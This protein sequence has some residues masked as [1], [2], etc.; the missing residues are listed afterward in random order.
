MPRAAPLI[1]R[2]I[3]S[4]C[5]EGYPSGRYTHCAI[6]LSRASSLRYMRAVSGWRLTVGEWLCIVPPPTRYP[7]TL[8]RAT[9]AHDMR[10]TPFTDRSPG[11]RWSLY[12]VVPWCPADGATRRGI[13]WAPDPGADRC[14]R[15]QPTF[16]EHG[17]ASSAGVV[18]L[19]LYSIVWRRT[20]HTQ[21]DTMKQA[22]RRGLWWGGC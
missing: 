16:G 7:L 14:M 19:C 18:R 5:Q 10:A 11:H 3:V 8:P 6:P 1:C 17:A 15:E 21:E 9:P 12:S 22:V 2:A 20:C 4:R 13:F